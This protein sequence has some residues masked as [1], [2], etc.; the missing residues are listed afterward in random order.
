MAR[1]PVVDLGEC[2]ECDGC[3]EVCPEVFRHNEVIGYIEVI[4]CDTY[5]E[6]EVQDACICWEEE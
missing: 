5:P 6:L 3:V 1:V 2:V 4:E